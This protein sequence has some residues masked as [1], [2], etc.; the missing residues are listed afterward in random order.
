VQERNTSKQ[1]HLLTAGLAVVLV[2]G[3]VSACT[4]SPLDPST[5]LN[6]Q[7]RRGPV[8]SAA[9]DSVDRTVPVDSAG[10]VIF[11]LSGIPLGQAF[12]D[13]TGTARIEFSPGAYRIQVSSCP[14]APQVPDAQNA[15]VISGAFTLVAF[16][17]EMS[18][19]SPVAASP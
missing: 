16:V 5:G 1:K 7:V 2:L 8:D 15:D 6:I 4:N 18:A 17:C 9:A 3:M 12:T 14:G 19:P 11:T 10:V 13:S